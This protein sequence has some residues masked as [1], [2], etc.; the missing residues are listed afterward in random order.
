[1]VASSGVRAGAAYVEISADDAPMMRRLKESQARLRQWVAENSGPALT[2]GTEA[3]VMAQGREGGGFLSGGLRGT[4]LFGT[5]MKFAAA[6]G[7]AKVAIADARIFSAL[8]QGDMEGARKAAEALP[9]GL[10]QVVKELAAGADAAAQWVALRSLGAGVDPY[11][12][13]AAAGAKRIRDESVDQ[14]NRGLKAVE[15][16]QK[17][18]QRATMTAREYAQV[19]VAGMNLAVDAAEKVLASKLRLIAVDEQKKEAAKI[20]ADVAR[21]QNLLNQAMLEYEKLT[22]PARE[23][24]RLE[25]QAMGLTA[26]KAEQLLAWKLAILD[27]TEEQARAE[28]RAAVE[29]AKGIRTYQDV[30]DFLDEREKVRKEGQ[31]LEESL[32]T[33]EERAKAEIDKAQELLDTGAIGDDTYNR[34]VRKALEDAAAAMPDVAAR[35]TVGVRGTFSAIEAAGLGAGGVADAMLEAQRQT[36]KN[37]EKIAQLAANLG[38]TYQ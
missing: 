26:D 9:F 32:R 23:Y 5:G 2:R 14:H 16:S 1:M 12:A 29:A 36:A 28:D 17:A 15:D 38:V 34:A 19:E 6:I 13:N 21:G 31:S 11:D 18:L 22:V 25:V 37:T 30:I 4:E 3:A 35:A 24:L 10:G 33:P 20:A 7:I 8:F 27:A